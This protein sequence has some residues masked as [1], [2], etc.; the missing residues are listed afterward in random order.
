MGSAG[1]TSE[2]HLGSVTGRGAERFSAPPLPG[3]VPETGIIL[4]KLLSCRAHRLA[5][6][7]FSAS[8]QLCIHS[9]YR[10]NREKDT[11][12][13]KDPAIYQRPRRSNLPERQDRRSFRPIRPLNKALEPTV[14]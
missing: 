4:R 5:L 11:V 2:R 9:I 12:H 13:S 1:A 6:D 7:A 3:D 8:D 10:T 14:R